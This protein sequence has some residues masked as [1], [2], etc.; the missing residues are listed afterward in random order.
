MWLTEQQDTPGY[1]LIFGGSETPSCAVR[2]GMDG[3]RWSRRGNHVIMKLFLGVKEE[4]CMEWVG[5]YKYLGLQKGPGLK[6]EACWAL[7]DVIMNC[8][9]DW[10]RRGRIETKGPKAREVDISFSWTEVSSV[11]TPLFHGPEEKTSGMRNIADMVA[12]LESSSGGCECQ[13]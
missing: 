12:Q 1:D 13:H 10:K 8:G 2:M 6:T 4:S 11:S 5:F 3:N 7:A 9:R